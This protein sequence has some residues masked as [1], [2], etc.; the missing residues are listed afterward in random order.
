MGGWLFNGA[1]MGK[2]YRGCG[3]AR[4]LHMHGDKQ[5][6]GAVDEAEINTRGPRRRRTFNRGRAEQ[7]GGG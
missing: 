7:E 5:G 1:V 6:T 4:G 2:L 3:R